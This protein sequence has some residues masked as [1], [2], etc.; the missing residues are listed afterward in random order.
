MTNPLIDTA[1]L[2]ED[3]NNPNLRLIDGSWHLDGHDGRPDF[4]AA[5]LPGAR[6][7]DLEAS[8]EQ[9][10]P[11][12]HMMPS[13]QVF[14]A[15]MSAMG[16]G[17]DDHIVVYDTV[18]IRSAPRVWWMLRAMGAT[19]VQ[20]LDGGLPKWRAEGRP[21]EH[22]PSAPPQPSRFE[23]QLLDDA[24]VDLDQVRQALDG[25][26]QVLDA[27]AAPRFRGEAVEPRPGLRSGH[28]PGALNL[29]FPV[30]L[31]ADGT[32]KK[33]DALEAAFREAGVDLDRP[34]ITSCGSGVTAAILTLG[35]AVLG[36]PSR[37]YDGSWAE[38]GARADAPVETG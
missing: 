14:D 17:K 31:N 1:T 20:V 21:M 28:M 5:R 38:W 2:A 33:G 36:R 37:L 8:S 35:L 13:A 11:L 18:G 30:L 4:E 34:V 32:M 19:Q 12:P 16:L 26:I 10:S 25:P 24:V 27:R 7:F 6:F 15:R 29:P 22:G 9:D 23:A 3:L